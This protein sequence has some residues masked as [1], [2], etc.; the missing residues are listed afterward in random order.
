[1]MLFILSW[2]F[3]FL[4]LS[5]PVV[6]PY[7]AKLISQ[8]HRPN[9]ASSVLRHPPQLPKHLG[10]PSKYF[11][12]GRSC[13][14]IPTSANGNAWRTWPSLSSAVPFCSSSF[15]HAQQTPPKKGLPNHPCWHRSLQLPHQLTCSALNDRYLNNN[16]NNHFNL[17]YRPHTSTG[18]GYKSSNIYICVSSSTR[19]WSLQRQSFYFL[20]LCIL[21][22]AS[23][24][25][26]WT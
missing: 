11:I 9:Q 6:S 22:R 1:M 19:L 2:Y 3:L 17:L 5:H 4:G 21:P 23:H 15:W 18:V 8:D 7:S 10:R 25:L 16:N 14:S 20:F 12:C 13:P 24:P 26:L